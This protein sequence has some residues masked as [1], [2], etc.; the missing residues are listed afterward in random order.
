MKAQ[1]KL[2]DAVAVR[3]KAKFEEKD[4]EMLDEIEKSLLSTFANN[5][6][7]FGGMTVKSK[8]K[9]SQN[10][11]EVKKSW[12]KKFED[13]QRRK[14][15]QL[16]GCGTYPANKPRS[17]ARKAQKCETTAK[18]TA[19]QQPPQKEQPKLQQRK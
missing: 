14:Y 15:R 18:E 4:R 1:A 8:R 11:W 3:N 10:L 19:K 13:M 9:N 2:H 12:F 16:G 17:K 6:K 7:S 5:S